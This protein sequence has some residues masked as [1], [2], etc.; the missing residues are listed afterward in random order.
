MHDGCSRSAQTAAALRSVN[1]VLREEQASPFCPQLRLKP[2]KP[3]RNIMQPFGYRA[4]LHD[5]GR[6][7]L[8][9]K[10]QKGNFLGYSSRSNCYIVFTDDATALKG[11]SKM[12]TSRNVNFSPDSFPQDERGSGSG[13][14]DVGAAESGDDGG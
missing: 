14:H 4:F 1:M 11:P 2:T 10:A 5:A 12:Y 6:N 13:L 9:S 3:S 7:M 8:D